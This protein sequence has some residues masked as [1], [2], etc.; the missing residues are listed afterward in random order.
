MASRTNGTS[1]GFTQVS[2]FVEGLGLSK[3]DTVVVGDD[4][5]QVIALHVSYIEESRVI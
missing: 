1:S 2:A 3:G 5:V 4:D